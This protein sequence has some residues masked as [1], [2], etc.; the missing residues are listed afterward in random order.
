MRGFDEV[1]SLLGEDNPENKGW[2]EAERELCQ[3]LGIR[4][5]HFDWS[6]ESPSQSARL[7][8]NYLRSQTHKIYIHDF[9]SDSQK[10]EY[11]L[12]ALDDR[13]CRTQKPET[14]WPGTALDFKLGW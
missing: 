9:S 11:L 14:S 8:V 10:L 2:I 4:Y 6:A 3:L 1:I 13:R 7:I 5:T 12:E